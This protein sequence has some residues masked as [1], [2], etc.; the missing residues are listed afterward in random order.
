[1]LI[2]VSGVAP[3]KGNLAVVEGNQSVVG[4]GYAVGVAAKVIEYI[5]GAAERWFGVDDPI[6]SKQWPEP[7]GEDLGLSEWSQIAGK[8]QL[9]LLKSQLEPVDELSAKYAPE[10][11]DRK[12]ESRVR[13]NPA[14]VIEGE[15][16][17]WDD[18]V[19]MGMN[20][21]FLVPGVQYA[22]EADLGAEMSWVTSHFE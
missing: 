12:K 6:F 19:D 22:E 17:G 21:E 20:L 14:C 16:T 3:T 15:P 10:H 2:V 4:D 18:A 9:P 5:L 11:I 7:R 8:V 13:P 1:L